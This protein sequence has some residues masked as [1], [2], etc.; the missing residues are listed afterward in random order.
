MRKIQGS[1]SKVFGTAFDPNPVADRGR[2]RPISCQDFVRVSDMAFE[3]KK[4]WL[5]CGDVGPYC[6]GWASH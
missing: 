1:D 2:G 3:S 5:V 6:H 4:S